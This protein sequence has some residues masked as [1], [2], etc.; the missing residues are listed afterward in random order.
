MNSIKTINPLHSLA[1]AIALFESIRTLDEAGNRVVRAG[2]RNNLI[3]FPSEVPVFKKTTRPDLQAKIAVL[4]FIRGWSTSQIGERYGIGRQRVAQIVTKWRV[5][6]VRHGYVQL[7]NEATL[8]PTRF[9]EELQ[10]E[11]EAG[12]AERNSTERENGHSAHR[13][14]L[15]PSQ[16]I[17]EDRVFRQR[18]VAPFNT[19][20][21]R[22]QFRLP[23]RPVASGPVELTAQRQVSLKPRC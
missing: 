17:A 15:K 4:Y 13:L 22:G 20:I 16:L 11:A 6:A 3:T 9:L 12:A 10:D 8:V 7:I 1:E 5:R 23:E 21:D 18:R 19:A 2:I 14:Q